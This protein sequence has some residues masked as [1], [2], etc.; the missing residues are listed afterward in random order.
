M[1]PFVQCVT[2]ALSTG[3]PKELAADILLSCNGE[4]QTVYNYTLTYQLTLYL[5]TDTV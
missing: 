3:I 2:E 4:V 5:N 1:Q